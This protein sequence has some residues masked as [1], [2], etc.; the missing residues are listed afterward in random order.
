MPPLQKQPSSGRLPL[1]DVNF[2]PL[3][4][5]VLVS[6]LKRRDS[7]SEVVIPA[8]R[9]NS[10]TGTSRPAAQSEASTELVSRPTPANDEL[11]LHDRPQAKEESNV[12]K[13]AGR[14]RASFAK[15]DTKDMVEAAG[16]HF[17]AVQH[18]YEL[19]LDEVVHLK[20][21]TDAMV[22]HLTDS[23]SEIDRR[24]L[25]AVHRGRWVEARRLLKE[26]EESQSDQKLADGVLS[27][28]M[29]KRIHRV[30]S[31]FDESLSELK[32]F[33]D[34]SWTQEDDDVAFRLSDGL[35]QVVTTRCYENSDA[36]QAFVG[37]CEYDLCK[38]Y[39]G[40]VK[41]ANLLQ[42]DTEQSPNDT[43]W[44]VIQRWHTNKEDNIL[45]VSCLDALDEPLGALWFSTYTPVEEGLEELRGVKLPP[46]KEGFVRVNLW[47][48]V[49]IIEP[50]WSNAS[51]TPSFKL[52]MALSRRPS[53]AA[54]F[55]PSIVQK[56]ARDIMEKFHE[57]L[58]KCSHLNERALFSPRTPFYEYVRRHLAE[59]TP[60]NK[61]IPVNP[62]LRLTFHKL[63]E[64]LPDDWADHVDTATCREAKESESDVAKKNSEPQLAKKNSEPQL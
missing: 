22:R 28:S 20:T 12:E 47:R 56:E 10:T 64:F 52:T 27:A 6:G 11:V 31:R 21:E 2:G 38:E 39:L 48:T 9:Q 24:V 60:P 30:A 26:A 51:N 54:L 17:S 18:G 46:P 14:H 37:L 7:E 40:T 44:Q 3:A 55:F 61:P 49:F 41:T 4:C 16:P 45:Q 63:S 57:Y 5:F 29:Q 50:W 33:T 53:T 43:I 34:S 23:S 25:A 59:K 58:S 15:Q 32:G 36:F 42:E 62:L 13:K 1:C 8:D 19:S 35:F